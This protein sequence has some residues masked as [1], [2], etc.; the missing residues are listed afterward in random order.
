MI[1]YCKHFGIAVDY[2]NENPEIMNT[3]KP[4]YNILLDDRAGLECAFN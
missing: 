1:E 2:I 3:R 4:Y